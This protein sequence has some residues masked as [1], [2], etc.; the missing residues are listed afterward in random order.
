MK[1]KI[2]TRITAAFLVA[3]LFAAMGG[4][5]KTDPGRPPNADASALKDDTLIMTINGSPVYWPEYKYWLNYSLQYSG[6]ATDDKTDWQQNV[7]DI[8]LREF[9]LQ[10]AANAI[11]LYRAMDVKAGELGIVATDED[12]ADID[13]I[14]KNNRDY[15]ETDEEYQ[16]Y[17]NEN[18]LS[19][20]LMHYLLVASFNYYSIFVEMFGENGE[21]LSDEDALIFGAENGYYRAK[22]ILMAFADSNGNKYSD[23]VMEQKRS[24]LSEILTELKATAEPN[25]LFN[26]YALEY[27]EDPGIETNPNGYQ[28]INGTM[29][30]DFQQTVE[31]LGN[32]EFSDIITIEDYGY[33]IIMRLPLDPD[34]VTMAD[35]STLRYNAAVFQYQTLAETWTAESTVVYAEGYEKIDPA[36][37]F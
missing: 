12:I 24:K 33:S 9:V 4:C 10:D 3:A 30:S 19:D 29:V 21:K 2:L 13:S 7:G 23:E 17:L 18:Y 6:Y 15:F 8:S 28:Y 27:S 31:S 16:Q 32:Y 14:M 25:A 35:G 22:H 1:T 11:A 5:S 26:T 37:W 20:E 34:G 36:D